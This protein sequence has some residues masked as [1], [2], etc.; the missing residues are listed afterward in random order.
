MNPRWELIHV[1]CSEGATLRIDN[2]LPALT[3]E[4]IEFLLNHPDKPPDLPYDPDDDL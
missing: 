4:Q 2:P 3:P 1:H